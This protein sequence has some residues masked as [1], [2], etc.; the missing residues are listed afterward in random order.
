VAGNEANFFVRDV[1]SGSRLPF[2]I[3]PGAPTSSLDIAADGRVGIG[4][5]S[6]DDGLDVSN[7]SIRISAGTTNIAQISLLSDAGNPNRARIRFTNQA[8][9]IRDDTAASDRLFINTNGAVTL[10]ALTNCASGIR[11]DG[12][13]LLSCIPST[14]EVKNVSGELHP[15]VAL[16]NVMA[17]RPQ[18]GSYKETPDEPEHWLIAEQAASVDP[19]LVG[20]ANG[21][22]FTVK[23]QNVVADL[24]AVVQQQQRMIEEQRRFIEEQR[25]RLEALERATASQK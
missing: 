19:A 24:V 14:I 9:A 10:A 18:V 1:T 3:R 5:A 11:S 15:Q 23:T 12:T 20:L 2:R 6:P 21:K 25:A 7:G 17:L 22:P 4:T 13:G 16:A 8:F